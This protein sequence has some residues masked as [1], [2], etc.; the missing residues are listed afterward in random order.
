VEAA[1]GCRV[2][3]H[4]GAAEMV[5]LV[6]QCEHGRYHPNP[7][8]GI[9][10]VLVD[11]RPAAPGERGQIVA[12]GFVNTVMP[13]I[14]YL[15]G[16]S[17]VVGEP[18]CPCRRA[19][20]VLEQIEGRFDDVVITPDGRRIGRLDPIFKSVTS[21]YETRIV[22]TSPSRVRV[23]IVPAERYDPADEVQLVDELRR[24]LGSSM[25]IEIARVQSIPRTAS[26]KLRAV[27]N[28]VVKH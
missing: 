19:F 14:R 17:A 25:Q 16:D 13:L 11:G 20:P 18:G 26:G 27:V 9:L 4:Y 5:A 1:F 7:E 15:T 24:R 8:F 21:F 3:D 6:T 12:T 23:E 22:Q 10:E 2:F 28:E